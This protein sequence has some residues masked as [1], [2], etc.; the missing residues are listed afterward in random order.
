[1]KKILTILLMAILMVCCVSTASAISNDDTIDGEVQVISCDV[2]YTYYSGVSSD[3]YYTGPNGGSDAYYYVITAEGE[4]QLNISNV[5]AD[6][7]SEQDYINANFIKDL[8]RSFGDE[9]CYFIGLHTGGWSD[10]P[11]SSYSIDGDIMTLHFNGTEITRY[12]EKSDLCD[13]W[14]Q[15]N[16]YVQLSIYL[17]DS[18]DYLIQ[19]PLDDINKVHG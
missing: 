7:V 2:T 15:N 8:N 1:M 17:P 5:T 11:I 18:P 12:N 4:L 9:D 3:Y 6:D 10:Y 19:T 13:E 16:A 14:D